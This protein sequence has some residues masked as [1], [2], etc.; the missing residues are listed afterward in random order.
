VNG[1]SPPAGPATDG[2]DRRPVE[3]VVFDVDGT[4]VRG[5]EPIPGAAEAVAAVRDRGLSV[6]LVSN[7]PVD[8]P[9]AYAERLAGAGIDV[10]PGEVVTSGMVTADR[11]AA[12]YPDDP[13][14]VVGERGLVDLL[15]DRG[16]AVTDDPDAARVVVG[17]IDRSFTYD[18]LTAAL[19]A[20]SGDPP[21]TFVATDPDR[22]IP[23]ADGPAPG[24]GAIVDAMASVAGR[25]PDRTMGKPGR[26]TRE[27]AFATLG[28]APARAL[29]VGDRPDTDV[30]MGQRAGARTVLVA[31]GVAGDPEE[32]D[33]APDHVLPSVADLPSLLDDLPV[34]D[35]GR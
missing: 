10:D 2:G 30:A 8:P 13:A 3:G 23:A 12:D 18:R 28:V 35:D 21:P 9:P 6:A 20:L 27:A 24:S 14:F 31:S 15:A 29:V 4:L 22:T 1:A 25:P 32:V 16:V 11:L 19:R 26:P 33:P 34:E 17:S 5:S 7:N